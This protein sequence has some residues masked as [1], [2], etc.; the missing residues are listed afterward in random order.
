MNAD[1]SKLISKGEGIDIE[2]KECRNKLTSDVFES[3]CAFLN[4]IGGYIILGVN[5][6][7]EI[8]GIEPSAVAQIKKDFV[9]TI[10]NPNKIAPVVYTSVTEYTIDGMKILYIPIPNSSQVHRLSGRI[11]DRN[12]DADID[13]TDST[14]LV[15][16]MYNRKN[17]INT[18]IR[19]FSHITHEDI[20]PKMIERVKKMA[21]SRRS[22]THHPWEALGD[23]DLL[24][25]ANLYGKDPNTGNEGMNLAGILLLGSEQLIVSVLPHHKTDAIAH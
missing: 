3:V 24:K 10:N 22:D 4:R 7:G 25:S 17:S 15:A 8:T 23:L 14:I 6:A 11:F 13:I 16:D 20:E 5:D 19:V 1:I 12:E 21:I 2:F 9:T 18:E